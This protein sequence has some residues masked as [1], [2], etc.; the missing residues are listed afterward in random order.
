MQRPED[1]P[2]ASSSIAS[3]PPIPFLNDT[4]AT[5]LSHQEEDFP[6]RRRE[7]RTTYECLYL[8]QICTVL[9]FQVF[10]AD[11]FHLHHCHGIC[12][13]LC[14]LASDQLKV[15]RRK[16]AVHSQK[17]WIRLPPFDTRECQKGS[18]PMRKAPRVTT[19]A[20]AGRKPFPATEPR[21][22]RECVPC[23][24]DLP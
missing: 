21:R 15:R 1:N 12:G 6:S 8:Y 7:A 23:S 24:F 4:P 3:D 5:L 19:V 9:G 22:S 17:R 16:V 13:D 2:A 20:A 18:P 14:Y 11:Q 10:E